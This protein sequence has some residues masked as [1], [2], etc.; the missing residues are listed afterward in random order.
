MRILAAS[1]PI[2]A[3]TVNAVPFLDGLAEQ[4]EEVHRAV[5]TPFLNMAG[6]GTIWDTGSVPPFTPPTGRVS[7]AS[8]RYAWLLEDARERAGQVRRVVEEVRPDVVLTDSLGYAAVLTC[9]QLGVPWVSFGDGPLHYPDRFTPPFGAGLPF[10]TPAPWR[11]RNA[12]VQQVSRRVLMAPAQRRYRSLRAE[13]GLGPGRAPVLEACLSPDL[14]LHC[15]VPELEYPREDLPAHVRFVGALRPPVP[16]GWEEPSWWGQLVEG[17]SGDVVLAT[18]GTLRGD[19]QEVLA[20]T[21]EMLRRTGRPG[22]LATGAGDPSLLGGPGYVAGADG[23]GVAVESFVPYERVLPHAGVL[24]TNGG[25][26]GVLL[27]L[28]HAVPVVQV[29]RT[30]EKAD[31]GRRVEWAGAGLHLSDARGLDGA[32]DR[33]LSDPSFR[34]GARR[35]AG[36]LARLDPG[37]EGARLIPRVASPG[38]AR[39]GRTIVGR[40]RTQPEKIR[41]PGQR[42]TP[43]EGGSGDG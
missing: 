43:S 39:D 22:V 41:W 10:R 12:V 18:Q 33:I 21:L 2:Y 32:V 17:R 34:A 29:G 9:E 36:A 26:T 30:E 11:W 19:V 27:A 37:R 15:G 8:R 6:P 14:H 5:A 28:A 40:L 31:I 20:P 13:L 23:S 1:S 24:V 25:W 7:E 4:G 38:A 42:R 16:A 3:H 35:V